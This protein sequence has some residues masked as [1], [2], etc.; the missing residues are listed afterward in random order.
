MELPQ[1]RPFGTEGKKPT[2]DF[3]SLYSDSSFQHQDPRPPSQ[4]FHLKTHDYFLNPLERVGKSN[5]TG[6]STNETSN[7]EKPS[8]EHTLPGGIGTYSISHIPSF[9]RG[10]VKAEKSGCTLVRANSI[11]RKVETTKNNS[12]SNSSSYRGGPFTLWEESSAKEAGIV[13]DKVGERQ[14]P[15]E[16][17]E[18][19]GQWAS[20]SESPIPSFVVGTNNSFSS[21]PSSK[22]KPQQKKIQGFMEMLKSMKGLPEEED[23]DDEEYV[24]REGSSHKGDLE[25]KVDGR[26][27]QRAITP[28]SKHSATEQRRRSKINDRFQIL[29]ELIPHSDQKRDKAS[30]LLEVIEY[31]QCLQE[32]VHKYEAAFPGWNLD[33]MKLM[34]WKHNQ[35][36]GESLT[37]HSRAMKNG[38]GHGLIFSG[39]FD[40]NNNAV[41]PTMHANMQNP[42][43]SDLSTGVPY[44]SMDHHPGLASKVASIP[45]HQNT[46]PCSVGG[47]SGPGQSLQRLMP[48]AENMAC[49]P[50]SHLWQRQCLAESDMRIEQEE[51]AIEGGTVRMSSVYSQQLLSSLTDAL[52]SSGI[53]LSQASISVQIEL[54]KRAVSGRPSTMTSSAKDHEDPSSSN[55]VMVHSR[56]ASSGEDS[57]HVHKRFKI[58]NS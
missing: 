22:Q 38:P 18:K 11:E 40:N 24:K 32:K 42:V 17:R 37:D 29:R 49:Q 57:D 43:E 48:D 55:R 25:V 31:I 13:K 34:P 20:S 28:R 1:P 5:A 15:R 54:G 6:E 51:L 30:F 36:T 14:L 7:V 16:V 2:H 4:G 23:D 27:D 33:S 21:Q 50:H 46:Y 58:D 39:N 44:T 8:V 47:S 26:G 19:L 12:N 9:K 35:G 56:V 41:S 52:Q 3:L 10:I 45:L 53:D